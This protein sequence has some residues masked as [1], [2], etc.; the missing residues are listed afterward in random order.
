MYISVSFKLGYVIWK[1]LKVN[2]PKF[3]DNDI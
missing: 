3:H 2:N 1:N